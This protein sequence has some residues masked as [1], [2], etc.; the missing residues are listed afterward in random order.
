MLRA[1]SRS[2]VSEA[3][4]TQRCGAAGARWAGCPRGDHVAARLHA[5]GWEIKGA[6][7][8]QWQPLHH[9]GAPL[10]HSEEI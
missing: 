7:S 4:D 3:G 5:R 9:S 8:Q 2:P 6:F 10:V 1:V